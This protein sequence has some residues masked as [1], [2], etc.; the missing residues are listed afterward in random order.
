MQYLPDLGENL[1]SVTFEGRQ[2][3]FQNSAASY[4]P[5]VPVAVLVVNERRISK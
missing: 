3:G 1:N 2:F 4:V 5:A